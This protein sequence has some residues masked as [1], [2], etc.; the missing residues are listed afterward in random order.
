MPSHLDRRGAVYYSRLVVPPRLRPIIGKSDLGRSLRTKDLAVAKDRLAAW[1]IEARATLTEAEA[2]HAAA[3]KEQ[4]VAVRSSP[5]PSPP[6]ELAQLEYEEELAAIQSAETAEEAWLI[7]QADALEQRLKSDDAQLTDQERAAAFLFRHL[8]EQRDDQVRRYRQRNFGEHTQIDAPTYQVHAEVAKNRQSNKCA[9]T[10]SQIFEGY[11]HQDGSNAET[12]KQFRSIIKHL[13]AYLGHDDARRVT[14]AD[15]V[16]W[17]EQLLIEPA[18]G[19]KPRSAKTINDSYLSAMKATFSYGMDKLFISVNP[20]VNVA[21]VRA[22]KATELRERDFIK[23]ERETILRAALIP[24]EGKLSG[25][26]VFARRW[27]PW[28]CA[29]TGARVNEITQLRKQDIQM[30]EGVWT[31]RITPEAGS[32]K[33]KKART[34]PLHEHLIEQGF[35]AAI[36]HKQGPLFY[37]PANAR[38]GSS[39]GQ[40]K[41]VGMYLARWVRGLGITDPEI[42]PNHAW[43]H[44][45]KTVCLEAG[46]EERAAD[47]MQGHSSKGQGRRYGSNTIPALAA[48]LAK[49]PRFTLG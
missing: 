8:E 3:N 43:R 39:R 13:T 17:R 22:A 24:A 25:E 23:A 20:S 36:N 16:G 33:T 27:V 44:T 30:I 9:V 5:P 6:W 2:K 48:Q 11:A 45:F 7:E 21:K 49:F 46:V 4:S 40:Y 29:Y 32:T 26:R 41:K 28:L 1:L 35:L 42:Q 37:N 10:I 15:L 38:G 31:V 47:Y 18:R 14:H 12:V 34:M 19:G